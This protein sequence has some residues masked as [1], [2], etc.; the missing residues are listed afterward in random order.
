EKEITCS[1]SIHEF[2]YNP[3]GKAAT[4]IKKKDGKLGGDKGVVMNKLAE[5]IIL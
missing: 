1:D 2:L 3:K 5:R 4:L